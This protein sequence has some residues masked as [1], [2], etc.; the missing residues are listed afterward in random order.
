MT[1]TEF[2]CTRYQSRKFEWAEASS[3]TQT[4]G[5]IFQNNIKNLTDIIMIDNILSSATSLLG[6]SSKYLPQ[7]KIDIRRQVDGNVALPS[8][9]SISGLPS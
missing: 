6:Q 5:N 9:G 2:R 7:D 3:T 4:Y 8:Q 1:V